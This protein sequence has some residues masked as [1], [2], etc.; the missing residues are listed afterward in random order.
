MQVKPK[1]E[2]IKINPNEGGKGK[3]ICNDEKCVAIAKK[4][5]RLSEDFTL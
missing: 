1:P 2:L 4:K 3:Y 5:K